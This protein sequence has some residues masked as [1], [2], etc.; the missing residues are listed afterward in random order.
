MA[1]A[2]NKEKALSV[3]SEQAQALIS[4]GNTGIQISATDYRPSKMKVFQSDK[5]Y[6]FFREGENPSPSQYGKL[7]T[8]VK[9]VEISLSDLKDSITGTL[10]KYD[11]GYN[12][13]EVDAGG[14]FI[15]F[16]GSARGMIGQNSAITPE[17]F[18]DK[19]PN[20]EYQN[21]AKILMCLGSAEEASDLIS[22]GG[23]PFTILELKKA[24]YG[25]S[26]SFFDKMS[27]AIS[28]ST[29]IQE[30]LRE[31]RRDDGSGKPTANVF[32]VVISS[33]TAT[34][35]SGA[36]FYIPKLTLDV[37]TIDDAV[38]MLPV[39]DMWKDYSLFGSFDFKNP[40]G[41]AAVD[42]VDVKVKSTKVEPDDDLPF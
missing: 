31:N 14:E 21:V 19:F 13:M 18:S 3:K 40:D 9:D 35:K 25:V 39:F 20:Y 15:E 36:E 8:S 5:Q 37:N 42:A 24:S 1:K 4:T 41:T 26:F 38:K 23:N 32:K 16:I 27:A 11:V 10:L 6:K 2:A 29:E 28:N 12:V 22:V 7:F 34:S 17:M 30:L 33:E